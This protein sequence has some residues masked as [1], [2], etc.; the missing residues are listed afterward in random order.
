MKIL[1]FILVIILSF[2]QKKYR[3]LLLFFATILL[4]YFLKQNIEGVGQSKESDEDKIPMSQKSNWRFG[5]DFWA[6]V[7]KHKYKIILGAVGVAV[8]LWFKVRRRKAENTVAAPVLGDTALNP[9]IK[10]EIQTK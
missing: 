4:F 1:L 5:I 8:C 10:T 2:K 6:A 9:I 7:K 3:N